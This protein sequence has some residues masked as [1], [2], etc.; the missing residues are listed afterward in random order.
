MNPGRPE[1][2]TA[3]FEPVGRDPLADLRP[4][5]ENARKFCARPVPGLLAEAEKKLEMKERAEP[6]QLPNR[7]VV[8][9]SL[10]N[11]SIRP[12]PR[13]N[14]QLGRTCGTSA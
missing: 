3:S 12:R 14:G 1:M 4:V 2:R 9:A 13:C 7:I 8:G 10:D 6:R 11:R 5:L